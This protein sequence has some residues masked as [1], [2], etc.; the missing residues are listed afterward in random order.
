M[1]GVDGIVLEMKS[2]SVWLWIADCYLKLA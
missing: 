2:V 1:D